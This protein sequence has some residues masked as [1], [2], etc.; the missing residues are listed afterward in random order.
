MKAT[1]IFVKNDWQQLFTAVKELTSQPSSK[2]NGAV[3][4][5]NLACLE[6]EGLLY[7]LRSS[8][9]QHVDLPSLPIENFH[10]P[11]FH[12]IHPS[13]SMDEVSHDELSHNSRGGIP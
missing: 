1:F 4:L 13:N 8:Y 2:Y 10:S 3:H 12:P 11:L 7:D 6:C 9:S 5:L